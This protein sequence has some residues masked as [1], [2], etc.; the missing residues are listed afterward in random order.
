MLRLLLLMGV[1]VCDAEHVVGVTCSLSHAF[2]MLPPLRSLALP[3]PRK[4]VKRTRSAAM[5]HC[6]Y[7]DNQLLLL[8]RCFF[9]ML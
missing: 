4:N 1:T 5:C 9:V 6:A 2:Y 7:E 3:T 8:L